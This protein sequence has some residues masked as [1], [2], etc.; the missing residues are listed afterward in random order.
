MASRCFFHE[1]LLCVRTVFTA[2]NSV[3]APCL[4]PSTT[5]CSEQAASPLFMS[6]LCMESGLTYSENFRM[7]RWMMMWTNEWVNE[8]NNHTYIGTNWVWI[9]TPVLLAS[10]S[11]F[12][13]T[14]HFPLHALASSTGLSMFPCS[15]RCLFK[16]LLFCLTETF[17]SV[18]VSLS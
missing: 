18:R 15:Q 12:L 11:T 5:N 17:T 1:S 8:W 13:R 9:G 4:V 3:W 7:S 14:P 2:G 10:L 6:S 16:F